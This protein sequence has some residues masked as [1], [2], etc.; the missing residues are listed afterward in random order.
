MSSA[1]GACGLVAG[2]ADLAEV[3]ADGSRGFA[4]HLTQTVETVPAARQPVHK[5]ME[6]IAR[7]TR[8][9]LELPGRKAPKMQ[10]VLIQSGDR[11]VT[12]EFD[13]DLEL[14]AG[15]WPTTDG[16]D[17]TD[18]VTAPNP[19]G[20]FARQLSETEGFSGVS[21]KNRFVGHV[22]RYQVVRGLC[23]KARCHK[24]RRPNA[25]TR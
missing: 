10:M 11:P 17:S 8:S 19:V 12:H 2:N 24:A 16:A 18:P 3:S 21:T 5:S 25:S 6:L 23:V 15:H 9:A 4:V 7:R 22:R 14:I 20:L 1:I 13:G